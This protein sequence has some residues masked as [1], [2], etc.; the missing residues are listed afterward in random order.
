MF[1]LVDY[2]FLQHDGTDDTD[3]VICLNLFNLLIMFYQREGTELTNGKVKT[4]NGKLV[5]MILLLIIF[6]DWFLQL[7]C[8]NLIKK[9]T[10]NV[11]SKFLLIIYILN[12]ITGN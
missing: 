12:M 5:W 11:L 2:L 7:C 3:K 9:I 1:N 8:W 4:E 10:F 6:E